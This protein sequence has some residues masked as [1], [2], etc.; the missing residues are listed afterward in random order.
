M[1]ELSLINAI[2]R[3]LKAPGRGILR[4]VG[5]D[6]AVVESRAVSVTSIDAV[7]ETT[8]FERATHSPK[9]IGHKALANALSDLAAMGADPGEAYISLA[10]SRDLDQDEALAIVEGMRELADACEITI[11]GGDV[12]V[13]PALVIT[14]AVVGWAE[15]AGEL[16]YRNGARPG[17]LVCVTGTLG[18]SGAGL[19]L[20]RHPD[21]ALDRASQ[22][23]LLERHRRPCPRLQAGKTLSRA[24]ASSMIDVSD[25]IASDAPHIAQSSGV[26]FRIA[27][28][29][30]P[31]DP[32]A[33]EVLRAYGRDP[34][35]FAATAGDDYELL[36]TVAPSHKDALESACQK[37]GVPISF[38]GTV[39]EG[40]GVEFLDAWGEAVELS[41]Y[42]HS[43]G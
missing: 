19:L 40:S 16:C 11:A 21:M 43:T 37:S 36:A 39:S 35:I 6:A 17:D 34:H 9:D 31:V 14:V 42:E 25:G 20:L 38:I 5:D 15:S 29:K 30:L 33:V 24:G 32:A 4:W 1:R 2:E 41:G 27:L 8:H 10:L 22:L 23:T 26:C 7:V 28:E 3:A 18:A 13:S 12:V